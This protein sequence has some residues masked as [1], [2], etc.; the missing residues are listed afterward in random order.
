MP[1]QLTTKCELL[2][3][4]MERDTS[5]LPCNEIFMSQALNILRHVLHVYTNIHAWD[6]SGEKK[7]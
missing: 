6:M 1:T 3:G 2:A 5:K 4:P 7:A